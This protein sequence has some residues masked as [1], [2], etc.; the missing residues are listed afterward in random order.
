MFE[1][2][3]CQYPLLALSQAI[4]GKD[5][6]RFMPRWRNVA[7]AWVLAYSRCIS[8]ASVGSG[9]PHNHEVCHVFPFAPQHRNPQEKGTA[10]GD[11]PQSLT[12][13][14]QHGRRPPTIEKAGQ[15]R[16]RSR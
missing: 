11:F 12:Q 14:R 4:S 9:R 2:I 1:S 7:R 13:P 16:P 3:V 6:Q 15:Y 5:W 8:F 10:Q